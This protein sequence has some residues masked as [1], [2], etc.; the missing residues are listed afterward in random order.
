MNPIPTA[1]GG[2]TLDRIETLDQAR[3]GHRQ[4]PQIYVL[5][6]GDW[7]VIFCWTDDAAFA[8]CGY[9]RSRDQG[10]TWETDGW[11]TESGPLVQVDANSVAFFDSFYALHKGGDEYAIQACFSHDGGRTFGP[12][13]LSIPLHVPG[14]QTYTL[15]EMMTGYFALPCYPWNNFFKAN[16]HPPIV[17]GWPDTAKKIVFGAGGPTSQSVRLADGRVIATTY[18]KG[19]KRG[20]ADYWYASILESTDKGRSWK[21]ISTLPWDDQFAGEQAMFGQHGFTEVALAQLTN[22]DLLTVIRAGSNQPMAQCRSSDAGR[23][24]TRPVPVRLENTGE[25]AKGVMPVMHRL[26]DGSV[27]C[28][29]GRPGI[30]LMRDPTG[31]GEHWQHEI[32]LGAIERERASAAG[33]SLPGD[34]YSTENVGFTELSPGHLGVVYDLVGW[35]ESSRKPW[36]RQSIRLAH[37]SVV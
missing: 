19:N 18:C 32:D 3:F 11:A 1:T 5:P 13:E 29:Y 9:L 12:P 6:C 35:Q 22:G 34:Y 7:M 17:P 16:G 37:L 4:F 24:W 27:A 10:G 20:G 30:R 23:S 2:L 21:Q 15:A 28:V 26:S 36:V 14:A 31:T 8:K 33:G 25:P